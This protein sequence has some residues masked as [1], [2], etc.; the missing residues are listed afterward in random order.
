MQ[1]QKKATCVKIVLY[2]SKFCPGHAVDTHDLG[3]ATECFTTRQSCKQIL[4]FG[5]GM[6]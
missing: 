3:Q 1:S 2:D 4:R 5:Q 6:T